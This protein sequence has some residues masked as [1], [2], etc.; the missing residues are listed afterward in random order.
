[1]KDVSAQVVSRVVNLAYNL[2]RINV[3]PG[4]W[5]KIHT[6]VFSQISDKIDNQLWGK[7]YSHISDQAYIIWVKR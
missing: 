7:I 1:M 5:G 6:D 3:S 2:V 4:I